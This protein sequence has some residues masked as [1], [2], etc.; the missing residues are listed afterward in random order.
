MNWPKLFYVLIIVLL[1]IPM[2]FLGANGFF[3]EYTGQHSY[4]RGYDDCYGKYQY[5][6]QPVVSEK[7]RLVI[8]DLQRKC[9]DEQRVAQ[10]R[11]EN[12]KLVYEG[13]KYVWISLFNLAVLLLA[14]FLPKLQES[15]SM[16]LFLGAIGATFGATI[17]YFDTRSKVGFVILVGTFFLML[18]FINQKK[19]S[20]I[21]MRRKK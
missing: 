5:P 14:V 18:F 3:P 20:F 17:R 9:Q 6:A 11:W 21:P 7:E 8:N 15:V 19:D 13:M 12:E 16:G 1:Y 2:A 10:D 4:F